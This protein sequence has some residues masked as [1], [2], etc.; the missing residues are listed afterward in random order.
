MNDIMDEGIMQRIGTWA[1][2]KDRDG[3]EIRPLISCVSGERVVPLE[4][5]ARQKRVPAGR[6]ECRSHSFSGFHFLQRTSCSAK[7][8][9]SGVEA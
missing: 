7:N 5:E 6:F 8:H 9:R 3:V 2:Q 4:L 1:K